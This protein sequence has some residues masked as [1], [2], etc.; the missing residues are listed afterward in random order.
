MKIIDNELGRALSAKDLAAY[1]GLD[2]K[3]VRKYYRELGGIRLGSRIVF[4]EK[5]LI[6]AIQKRTKLD[7]PDSEGRAETGESVS[8]ESGS[9]GLGG[10]NAAKARKRLEQEDRHGLFG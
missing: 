8:D 6:N 1:L 10:R 5:E 3:T 2:P 9:N 4:F 7:C